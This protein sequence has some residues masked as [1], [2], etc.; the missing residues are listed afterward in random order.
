MCVYIYIY[1][2]KG[3]IIAHV[4]VSKSSN[5][6]LKNNNYLLKNYILIENTQVPNQRYY[7]K[8]LNMCKFAHDRKT[9]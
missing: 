2:V 7:F 1:I 8:L 4:K 6:L 3:C 5:Y 9:L